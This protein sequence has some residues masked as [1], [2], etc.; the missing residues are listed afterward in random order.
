MCRLTLAPHRSNQLTTM[1]RPS[2]VMTLTISEGKR[3]NEQASVK[4]RA[5]TIDALVI[6]SLT[7][8]GCSCSCIGLASDAPRDSPQSCECRG[9]RSIRHTINIWFESY[10]HRDIRKRWATP[11]PIMTTLLKA[12]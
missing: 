6:L 9:A 4:E 2:H 5:N 10:R 12:D 1:L 3:P 11:Q 8:C 7:A